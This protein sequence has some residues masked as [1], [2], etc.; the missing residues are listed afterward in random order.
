MLDLIVSVMELHPDRGSKLQDCR[1]YDAYWRIYASTVM[2]VS[3]CCCD[4]M[5][6][7]LVYA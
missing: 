1:R 6:R 2:H 5:Q 4:R 7:E 3:L